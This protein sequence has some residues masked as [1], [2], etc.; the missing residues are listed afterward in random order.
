[1]LEFQWTAGEQANVKSVTAAMKSTVEGTPLLNVWRC[2]GSGEFRWR[3]TT[4]RWL[5]GNGRMYLTSLT[6]IVSA[7]RLLK[8][9]IKMEDCF[10]ALKMQND[11]FVDLRR[12]RSEMVE[13]VRWKW[14]VCHRDS[15]VIE[16]VLLWLWDSLWLQKPQQLFPVCVL[17]CHRVLLL[18]RCRGSGGSLAN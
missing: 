12:Q 18:W 13:G 3:V 8:V 7:C 2:N 5:V 15:W 14:Q 16:S 1:M 17:I 4:D 10:R 6:C 9:I 11:A